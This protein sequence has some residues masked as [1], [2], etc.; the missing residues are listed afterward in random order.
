[1]T[2]LIAFLMAVATGWHVRRA[3]VLV[4]PLVLAAAYLLAA[5][6]VVE[7]RDTPALFLVIAAEVGLG[8][9][10]LGRR[11]RVLGR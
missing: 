4:V 10:L 1:M 11:R 8:A 2:L 5:G 7:L 3:W 9:G 6:R